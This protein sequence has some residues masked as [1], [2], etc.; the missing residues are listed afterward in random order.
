MAALAERRWIT[1]LKVMSSSPIYPRSM[2]IISFVSHYLGFEIWQFLNFNSGFL[3]GAQAGERTRD[4]FFL[5]FR[6]FSL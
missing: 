5:V 3:K 6:L 4:L 1:V 2:V